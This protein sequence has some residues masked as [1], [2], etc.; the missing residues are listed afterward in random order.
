MEPKAAIKVRGCAF[1]AEG[2]GRLHRTKDFQLVERG[3]PVIRRGQSFYMALLLDHEREFDEESDELQLTFSCG[4]TSS[5]AKGTKFVVP[6]RKNEFTEEEDNGSQWIARVKSRDPNAVTLEVYMYAFFKHLGI[7]FK[8]MAHGYSYFQLLT[9]I[10]SSQHLTVVLG[11]GNVGQQPKMG[12]QSMC[13]HA[14]MIFIYCST[15]G[16]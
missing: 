11:Y 10:R 12:H 5:F 13:I 3:T 2:N 8:Y 1:Y 16:N 9:S 15:P 14:R 6:V 4:P 7:F